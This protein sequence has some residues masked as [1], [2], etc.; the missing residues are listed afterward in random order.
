M[1]PLGGLERDLRE[2][3]GGERLPPLPTAKVRHAVPYA[4]H[5]I[6][7]EQTHRTG[8]E[9]KYLLQ[10]TG[11]H[12]AARQVNEIRLRQRISND[13]LNEQLQIGM[14]EVGGRV[15]GRKMMQGYLRAEGVTGLNNAIKLANDLG[16]T[17][18]GAESLPALSPVGPVRKQYGH[19][20]LVAEASARNH[21]RRSN[22]TSSRT[23]TTLVALEQE[24]EEEEQKQEEEQEQE[25]EK[26]EQEQEQEQKERR[27]GRRKL[28]SPGS[29][30][31]RGIHQD[32][33]GLVDP[34]PF[35]IMLAHRIRQH[36][37]LCPHRRERTVE[38]RLVPTVVYR[39]AL[40]NQK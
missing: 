25:Q 31:P 5:V 26:E 29:V 20:R 6:G 33:G 34:F 15:T 37:T 27:Q 36:K 1:R 16:M 28:P 3:H 19:Q 40:V 24:Q 9:L 23:T 18:R 11:A 13:D 12:R 7:V 38:V 14:A 2:A 4:Q 35:D 10:Q 17:T 21:I 30:R 8:L 32:W 22:S 39:A